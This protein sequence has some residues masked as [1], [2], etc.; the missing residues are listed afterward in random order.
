M[1]RPPAQVS[2]E[3]LAAMRELESQLGALEARCTKQ[4]QWER[5]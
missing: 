1:Q 2:N 3:Q 5:A 4:V